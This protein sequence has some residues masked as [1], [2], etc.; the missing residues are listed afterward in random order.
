MK[1][2]LALALVLCLVGSLAAC[3]EVAHITVGDAAKLMI[4]KE[5]GSVA[6]TLTD[7]KTVDNITGVVEKIPL[8]MAEATEDSWTYKLTWQDDEGKTITTVTL[9]GTQ[10]R[11]EG[12]SYSLGVGVDLSVITDVLETIPGLNK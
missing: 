10:L 12:N 4:E 9:A 3:T 7:E 6:I 1:K 5:G 11:W 2:I 8:Q